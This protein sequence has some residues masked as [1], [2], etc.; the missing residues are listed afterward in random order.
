MGVFRI[1]AKAALMVAISASA[2][3]S[4]A[5]VTGDPTADGGWINI[6][7]S[8]APGHYIDGTG[9]Y[10]ANVYT[11]SFNLDASSPLVSILGG[12]IWAPGDVIVGVAGIM[13]QTA[14]LT[15]SGGADVNGI[16]HSRATSARII[17]KYG[18]PTATWTAP[19]GAPGSSGSFGNGGVGSVLLGTNPYDF[20]PA[21]SG[22][23]IVPTSSPLEQTGV[24]TTSP[25]SGNV[26]R[27]VTNW[28]GAPGSETLNGFESFVNL[29]LLKAQYPSEQ[30]ALGSP[31]VLDLQRGT[32][33]FQNSLGSLPSSVP[34]PTLSA[35]ISLAVLG[36]FRRKCR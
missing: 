5:G 31:F 35:L 6:G 22:T 23:I 36:L 10:Q 4:F 25:I 24:S 2:L 27:V 15:Y 18:T 20:Y 3:P 21:D 26:G 1:A 19:A 16:A 17:A 30:V 29:T 33:N 14:D 7:Q 9:A 34:E 11:T 28:V 12:F 8:V 32:G 13:S